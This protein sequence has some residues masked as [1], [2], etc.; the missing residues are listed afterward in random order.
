MRMAEAGE[1]RQNK[2]APTRYRV[3]LI[4]IVVSPF[5]LFFYDAESISLLLI[6]L[7]GILVWFVK[8]NVRLF[9]AALF[10]PL[11]FLGIMTLLWPWCFIAPLAAYFLV[12]LGS[13]RFRT[14][15]TPL[16]TGRLDSCLA[17][18]M[19]ATILIS[20][21]SL[22]VWFSVFHPRL[23]DLTGMVPSVGPA[24]LIALAGIFSILN[25]A[26]EELIFRGLAWNS[27][28]EAFGSYRLVNIGQAILY[29]LA[30]AV[31][32]PRGWTGIV[33]A[34]LYGYVLGAM[35]HRSEG[36]L[37]PTI[38]HIFADATICALIYSAS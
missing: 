12:Y 31:G 4:F 18:W 13:N 7:C 21:S 25:A 36:L 3:L 22:V 2:K 5:V 29:G 19:L 8:K 17:G 23:D 15:A 38:T 10:W 30:H 1:R 37:A 27:L 28:R 20:S 33:M 26:W 11:L 16:L 6:P 9:A 34:T 35:R 24:K 14:A 32:F